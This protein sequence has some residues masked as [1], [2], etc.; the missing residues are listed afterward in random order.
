MIDELKKQLKR[1][2]GVRLKVY[3]DSLGIPT[4]GI[5]RN[6]KNNGIS[7]KEAEILLDNDLKQ[8]I[9]KIELLFPWYMSLSDSRK[10]VICNMVFNLGIFGFCKFQNM[11]SC[12]ESGDYYGAAREMLSSKW[13]KQV[14]DRAKELALI[15]KS[16]IL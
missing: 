16:G 7:I 5:G 14:G 9:P 11:I 4:I 15:M 12:I 1:H 13:A 6:L 8:L 3:N 2:E 10:V